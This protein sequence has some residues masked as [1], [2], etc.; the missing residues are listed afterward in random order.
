M[1]PKSLEHVKAIKNAKTTSQQEL[2]FAT[3]GCHINYSDEFLKACQLKRRE[4]A[5]VKIEEAKKKRGEY[6]KEQRD[7]VMLIRKKGELTVD[8]EK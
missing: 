2:F 3:G 4:E 1:A 7:A 8:T 6:C 5:I